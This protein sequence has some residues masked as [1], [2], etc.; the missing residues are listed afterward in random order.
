MVGNKID[1]SVSRL[2]LTLIEGLISLF[3]WLDRGKNK[4][5][6][7]PLKRFSATHEGTGT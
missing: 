7:S 2:W 3:N 4:S 6:P 1:S 5:N